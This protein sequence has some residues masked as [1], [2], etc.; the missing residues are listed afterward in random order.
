MIQDIYMFKYYDKC[1]LLTDI[2]CIKLL[3]GIVFEKGHARDF[4]A[5][6]DSNISWLLLKHVSSNMRFVSWR[7]IQTY[8]MH[9]VRKSNV[10]Y[11]CRAQIRT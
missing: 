3:I 10:A 4:L 8:H 7:A 1:N 11:A 5:N 6:T 2:S 9:V